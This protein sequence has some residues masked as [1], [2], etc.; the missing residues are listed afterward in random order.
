MITDRKKSKERVTLQGKF[1]KLVDTN[2][3]KSFGYIKCYSSSS[4]RPVKSPTNSIWHNCQK[5]YS[6][7]RK[8]KTILEIRK[9]PHFS[10]WSIILNLFHI[11]TTAS[12]TKSSHQGR[13][14]CYLQLPIFF[15]HSLL[16]MEKWKV[17]VI[18]V[19]LSKLD[20]I[21]LLNYIYCETIL[22]WGL[23]SKWLTNVTH[24][25]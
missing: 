14:P 4:P 23:V 16:P 18:H 9:R 10:R 21:S 19:F 8:P 22:V 3:V 6:W 17:V 25:L 15:L 24:C 5:I 13:G 7:L 11:K 20:R 2:S 12:V 1:N